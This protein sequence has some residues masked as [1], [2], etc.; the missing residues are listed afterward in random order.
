M[1]VG[2][3]D[4]IRDLV[5]FLS[6]DPLTVEDVAARVGPVKHD[7]GGLMPIEIHPI[8]T[9]LRSVRLMRYPNSGLP[10]MLDLDL[11]PDARLT[12]AALKVVFGDYHRARTDRGR[13]SE[14]LFYP[15]ATGP[16]WKVVVIAELG[17]VVDE[18]D[19][20]PVTSIA[21]R[22]DPASR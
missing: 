18:L 1:T 6:Q 19:E 12:A 8:L 22:R 13:P 10:Y 9:G 4:L 11:M 17:P 5:H 7:P 3:T 21:L 2:V 20:A 14:I 16:R 15:P